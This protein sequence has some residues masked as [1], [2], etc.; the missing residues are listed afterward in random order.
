MVGDGFALVLDGATSVAM[1]RSHDPGWYAERL[2][3]EIASRLPEGVSLPD[4]VAAAI[5]AVRDTY[6]LVARTSPTSTVAIARWSTQ[7]IETFVLCDS[8][9]TLL[10]DDGTE[11]VHT[12]LEV[13]TAIARH[14]ELYRSR[15]ATGHGF[16]DGHRALLVELQE[17]QARRRNRPGGYWV[18][19]IEPE[20][21]YHG[22][23]G[24]THRAGVT[25]LV[26]ATDGVELDRH[27]RASTWRDVYDEALEHGPAH[28]LD[29]VHDAEATDPD[30]VRWARAKRHDDKTLVIVRLA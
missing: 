28:V 24:T 18:A 19:G 20:A 17:E 10:H 12:D 8:S 4:T 26:L 11:K 13:G 3:K 6:G 9:V 2:G 7:T 16:D 27:P 15:L 29:A 1:D 5:T 14:R 21:A 22:H 25:A 30:G 23:V